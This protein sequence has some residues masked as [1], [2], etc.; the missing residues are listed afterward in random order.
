M[1]EK[2]RKK[3][4]II[5]IKKA[6]QR[7]IYVHI[8]S[9]FLLCCCV[10]KV[11][12]PCCAGPPARH[13]EILKKFWL[14]ARMVAVYVQGA[15]WVRHWHGPGS[16]DSQSSALVTANSVRGAARTAS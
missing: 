14:P 2:I 4:S 11:A 9:A 16:C 1:K 5:V 8:Q 12:V 3:N 7:T 13:T 10:G 15:P 6:D